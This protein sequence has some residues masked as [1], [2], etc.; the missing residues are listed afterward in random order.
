MPLAEV[1]GAVAGAGKQFGDGHFPLRE[2]VKPAANRDRMRAGTH[3]K[4]PGQDG[5][6]AR[7]TLCLDVE[8]EQ[9]RAFSR[10]LVDAGRG[11]APHH[12]APVSAHLTITEIVHQDEDDVGLLAVT[13]RRLL[14]WAI[15]LRLSWPR[16]SGASIPPDAVSQ[17]SKAPVASRTAAASVVRVRILPSPFVG[18]IGV[19]GRDHFT[20]SMSGSFHVLSKSGFCGP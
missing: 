11:R 9:S 8:V 10:E 18:L 14:R 6:A 19:R 1:A 3:G 7:G 2:S 17:P 15:F 4:A 12:A 13:R 16:A 5:R 20:F